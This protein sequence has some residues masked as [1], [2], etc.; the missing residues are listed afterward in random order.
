MSTT[1]IM[2]DIF[3][4]SSIK[5]VELWENRGRIYPHDDSSEI[6]ASEADFILVEFCPLLTNVFNYS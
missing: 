1:V 6:K 4:P 3:A 2:Y 5:R